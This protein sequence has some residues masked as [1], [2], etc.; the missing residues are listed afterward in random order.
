MIGWKIPPA[1]MR[2]LRLVL[3][4]EFN[5]KFI[6]IVL[7]KLVFMALPVNP[8]QPPSIKSIRIGDDMLT[9]YLDP[10]ADPIADD[11]VC[12]TCMTCGP[13]PQKFAA[14]S[15]PQNYVQMLFSKIF[16]IFAI[17]NYKI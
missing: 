5:V 2:D 17:E 7:V 8:A 4:Y 13:P 1:R 3:F 15:K 10:I 9:P 6:F 11:G 16:A 14:S 12:M